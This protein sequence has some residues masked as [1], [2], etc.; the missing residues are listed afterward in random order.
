MTDAATQQP[1][2]YV[3]DDDE[4]VRDSIQLLLQS[5][6]HVVETF[7][8][9]LAFLNAAPGITSGCLVLASELGASKSGASG[10]GT[11]GGVALLLQLRERGIAIPAI[12]TANQ[13]GV[14]LA[15]EAMRAGAADFLEKPLLDARLL[16]AVKRVMK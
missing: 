12:V 2:V 16:L 9:P 6:D 15:V 5:V 13:G 3:V 7:D 14:P 8:S 11:P 1:K 4:A 10:L